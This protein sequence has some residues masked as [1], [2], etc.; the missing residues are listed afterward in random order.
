MQCSNHPSITEGISRCIRCA[1]PFCQSCLVRIRGGAYCAAC[2]GEQVRDIQSGTVHGELELATVGR[3]FAALWVDSL[4]FTVPAFLAA[5]LLVPLL[6]TRSSDP[7]AL[8]GIVMLVL[9]VGFVLVW[10]VYEGLM[11]QHRG[12]TLGKMALGIKV[13][14]PEGDDISAGQAWG[15]ALLRQVFFSYLSLINYA[16]VLFTKQRTCIHDLVAKT[17]VE[18]VRS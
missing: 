17:R 11:L 9:M 7:E 10:I 14:S 1:R 16:P 18:R 8:G 6:A 2:K 5:M 13:V 4:V 15:R 12:Q 3:R